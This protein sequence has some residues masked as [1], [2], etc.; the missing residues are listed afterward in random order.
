ML[1]R[2]TIASHLKCIHRNER[3]LIKAPVK[4]NSPFQGYIVYDSRRAS[5][6]VIHGSA[7]KCAMKGQCFIRPKDTLLSSSLTRS[8]S[9]VYTV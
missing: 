1:G 2:I 9:V 8:S 7:E 5:S 6:N 3:D 4:Y